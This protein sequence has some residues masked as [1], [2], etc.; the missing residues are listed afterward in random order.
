[1]FAI[2]LINSPEYVKLVYEAIIKSKLHSNPQ[3]DKTSIYLTI[4]KITREYR[5]NLSKT[6]KAKCEI[7]IKKIKDIESKA[8]RKA[9]DN[10]RV[11]TD[12]VYNVQQHVSVF[13][14]RKN[15][16]IV[17]FV[18]TYSGTFLLSLF[19]KK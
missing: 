19:N 8:F 6:V 15:L 9:K 14:T 5:E 10:K 18:D 17:T 7:A 1:M 11:S 16:S 4:P 12:L 3:M 13:I 2:D